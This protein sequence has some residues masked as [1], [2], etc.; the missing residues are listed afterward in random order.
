MKSRPAKLA[1]E[2]QKHVEA[3]VERERRQQFD[4]DVEMIMKVVLWTLLQE[5]DWKG[6][7]LSRFFNQV[8]E[9][10]AWLPKQYEGDWE[11]AVDRDLKQK[12]NLHFDDPQWLKERKE[13]AKD[14]KRSKTEL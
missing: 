2:M 10:F 6:L 8:L 14:A 9:N 1:P 5:N 12:A 13:S 11:F 4:H 7:R 3:V